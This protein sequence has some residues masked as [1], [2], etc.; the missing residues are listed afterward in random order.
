MERDPSKQWAV[1][2]G[3]PDLRPGHHL[4]LL[5][6]SLQLFPALVTAIDAARAEVL[7]ET[8]IFDFTGSAG[9]VAHALERAARRG[10][11]VRVVVDGFGTRELQP[12][13][14]LRLEAAGV[15][16]LVY[17]PPGPLGM[18]VPGQWR[19]L[20]RKLCAVDGEVGFCG[21]INMLDDFHDP[22]HGALESPRLDFAIRVVGP[23]VGEMRATM[24]RQLSRIDA[25]GQLKRAHWIGAL[26]LW[27]A[28]DMPHTPAPPVPSHGEP[29]AL[30]ALL[31]RDNLRFRVGI[32][33]AYLRAIGRARQ[34]I[35]I[36]NAYFVPGGRIR[37]ALVQAAQRGVR[38]SLL[39]QGRYE[40]FMQYYAARP[41]FGALLQAGVEIHEYAPSFLHAKVAVIDGHWATVG[42]SNLDPLSFLLAREANVVVDD[43]RFAA[44]LRE[45][46]LHAMEHQGERMDAAGY[47]QRPPL[48]RAK[49]WVARVLMRLAIIVQG[50]RY[51]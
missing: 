12:P 41:V 46:L 18:L 21:G 23:L 9:D 8:Y 47:E 51:K 30:A 33:R 39:L 48:Q 3:V 4:Q 5:E 38:V 27:R 6:G 43:R 24:L 11:A 17:S 45:R 40:Y 13:W 19:R 50:K 7:L 49:E 14:R 32:E 42:S 20:H 28:V 15:Q 22:N 35:I 31:L 2:R 10:V 44:R 37:R 29:D 1:R 16:W 26:E 34:E 36:A 25:M